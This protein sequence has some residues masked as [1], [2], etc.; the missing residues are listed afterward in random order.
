MKKNVLLIVLLPALAACS[1]EP[2]DSGAF[3]V[4]VEVETRGADGDPVETQ[5]LAFTGSGR[6]FHR[7]LGFFRRLV[8]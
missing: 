2:D 1:T 7:F 5:V 3:Y 4:P 8:R 6:L